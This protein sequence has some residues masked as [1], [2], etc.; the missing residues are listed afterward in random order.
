MA[1][2]RWLRRPASTDCRPRLEILENRLLLS[3][4]DGG[5]LLAAPLHDHSGPCQLGADTVLADHAVAQEASGDPVLGYGP[6]PDGHLGG[7]LYPAGAPHTGPYG[8]AAGPAESA[9]ALPSLAGQLLVLD[10]NGATVFSRPGDFYLGAASVDV[11]PF[12]LSM[13]GWGGRESEAINHIVEFLREDFAAYDLTVSTVAPAVGEYNIIYVGGSNDWYSGGNQTL[14]A[15]THDPN[16]NDPSNYGFV[17]TEELGSYASLS[18]GDLL[19]FSE[20]VANLIAHETGHNLGLAHVLS[21]LYVM[22]SYL[23]NAP[24]TQSFGADDQV[25]NQDRL[26]NSLGHADG[27]A[28]DFG[29]SAAS[30]QPVPGNATLRGMLERRTDVDAFAV[31]S[32]TVTCRISV[33]DGRTAMERRIWLPF[34]ACGRLAR[35]RGGDAPA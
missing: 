15:A 29:D 21:T 1:H 18:D 4:A 30:A 11:P 32:A 12:Q 14:G 16:N 26:F 3:A 8:P 31:N 23:P 17:F 27:I 7:Q 33:F 19:K 20:Y 34:S 22:N 13:F 6:L 2:G 28:D 24:R 25:D 10:F 5:D 9:I 35:W